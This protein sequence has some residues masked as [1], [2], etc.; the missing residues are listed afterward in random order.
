[1]TDLNKAQVLALLEQQGYEVPET[2]LTEIVHR[3]NALVDSLRE[4]DA[5]DVYRVEPWPFQPFRRLDNG[6]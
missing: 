1:M 3:I 5:V 2:D 6:R 4:I